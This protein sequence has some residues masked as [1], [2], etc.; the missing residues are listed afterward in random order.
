MFL[1]SLFWP[2]TCSMSL[3]LSLC[4]SLSLSLFCSFLSFFLLVFLFCFFFG[5]FFFSLSSFFC[6][7]CFCFMKTNNIKIINCKVFFSSILCLFWVSCLVYLSN[8]FSYLCFSWYS[9]MFFVQHQCFGFKKH[10]LKNTNFGSKGELQQNGFLITCV[11]Q[12]VKSYRFVFA[13]FLAK[14]WLMFKKHYTNRHISAHFQK[15]K[16]P[17]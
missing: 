12:N 10:K 13:P 1:Q 4:L 16:R 11:L 8:P 2:S 14:F 7:L 15:Q 6:L 17:F 3:S 5:S 9:V